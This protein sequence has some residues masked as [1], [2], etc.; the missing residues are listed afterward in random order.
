MSPATLQRA[1]A[2][3]YSPAVV[4]ELEVVEEVCGG[5]DGLIATLACAPRSQDLDYLLNLVA[6]PTRAD[7]SLAD[8]CAA[9]DLR[10]AELFRHLKAGNVNKAQAIASQIYPQHIA[11]VVEDVFTRAQPHTIA[12]SPCLGSGVIPT[13]GYRN[14]PAGAVCAS[15]AGTG[16]HAVPGDL[17]RANV[18][19]K[20]TGLLHE[21]K[22]NVNVNLNTLVTG[23]G[24]SGGGL[25]ASVQADA[26]RSLRAFEDQPLPST[27]TV[28]EGV[29]E[30]G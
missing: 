18:V 2:D 17:A 11:A 24:G 27:L 29:V 28:E 13:G 23:G 20:L 3:I 19:F 10:P 12:C 25:L 21:E 14:E 6:D 5:R 30:D 4:A 7:L 22:G 9:A 1:A 26:A 8:L 16:T 15:C